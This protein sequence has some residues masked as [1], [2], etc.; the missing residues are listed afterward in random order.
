MKTKR[1]LV[2]D[3]VKTHPGSSVTEIYKGT[4]LYREYADSVVGQLWRR[5]ELKRLETKPATYQLVQNP[6]ILKKIPFT[7]AMKEKLAILARPKPN[8]GLSKE[9]KRKIIVSHRRHMSQ[10]TKDKIAAAAKKRAQKS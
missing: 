9:T 8:R 5:G 1:D 4:G 7:E 6:K 10:K 2:R 3:F